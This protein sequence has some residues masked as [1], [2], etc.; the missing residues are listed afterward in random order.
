MRRKLSV[1]TLV[2][3]AILIAGCAS[4]QPGEALQPGFNM[5]SKEQ[6]IQ[7]GRELSQQI[8]QQYPVLRNDFLQSY[9]DRIGQRL[10][11]QPGADNYPYTF[12]V[13]NL[14]EINAFALPGGPT[15]VN[16]GLIEAADNE[17][18]LAGVIAHEISHVAL[19]HGT[20]QASKANL[21]QLPAALAAGV[22]DGGVVGQ[23]AHLGIGF[24]AQSV[25][26]KY[27]RDAEREA[28]ALGARLM[29]GAG[30]NPIESARFFE[31]L[32]AQGGSRAPQFLSS[33]P[34][35]GNRIQLVEAEIR[36]I[37]AGRYGYST[38]QF[39]QA[40][41]IARSIQGSGSRAD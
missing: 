27:S 17:A 40:Q 29:G 22:I 12:T 5:F 23:L 1:Y 15:Y 18:Q 8:P 4:R 25:L 37:P 24:G 31:K 39:E 6:D 10:A 26:L 32:E 14:E 34:S 21:V 16:K 33:H 7:L 2:A 38:G 30:Y 20:S 35:P 36:H 19:R 3:A 28:D 13:L 9:V 11:R 41:R